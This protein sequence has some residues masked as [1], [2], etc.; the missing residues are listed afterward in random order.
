M[1]GKR[2]CPNCGGDNVDLADG[3]ITGSY[4]CLDC[5][6]TGTL[7][8]ERTDNKDLEDMDDE[9]EVNKSKT[10][11][12]IDGKKKK[13]VKKKSIKKGGKKK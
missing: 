5:D 3:A 9:V 1:T 2:F 4:I 10:K 8:P 7:F 12:K 11:K 13:D 6:Y